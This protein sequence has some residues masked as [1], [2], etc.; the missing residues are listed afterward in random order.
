PHRP[1]RPQAELGAFLMPTPTGG[2]RGRRFAVVLVALTAALAATAG[3]AQPS[4]SHAI[5]TAVSASLHAP[6]R[7]GDRGQK[8]RGLQW[9]LS[10]HRPSVYRRTV[11]PYGGRVDGVYGPKTQ[12]AVRA[13]K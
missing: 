5:G 6:L 10:G 11:H 2:R 4:G 8:V 1:S 13:A 9:L 7:V 3:P 12:K